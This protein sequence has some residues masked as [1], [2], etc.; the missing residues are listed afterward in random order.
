M[1]R[2]YADLEHLRLRKQQNKSCW[3]RVVSSIFLCVP[4]CGERIDEDEVM[5]AGRRV[6]MR[7]E[8]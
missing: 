5:G 6:H 3:A 4:L 8:R 7:E 1:T 2:L